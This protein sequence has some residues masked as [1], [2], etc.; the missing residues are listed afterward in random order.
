MIIRIITI[1]MG[2]SLGLVTASQGAERDTK[3]NTNVLKA[4][5]KGQRI[6][7]WIPQGI[8]PKERATVEAEKNGGLWYYNK[9]ECDRAQWPIANLGGVGWN[10]NRLTGTDHFVHVNI[11][12]EDQGVGDKFYDRYVMKIQ[13]RVFGIYRCLNRNDKPT[14]QL[15]KVMKKSDWRKRVTSCTALGGLGAVVAGGMGWLG[16]KNFDNNKR[17]SMVSLGLSGVGLLS[18]MYALYRY[19]TMGVLSLHDLSKELRKQ[20]EDNWRYI[21]PADAQD[22]MDIALFDQNYVLVMSPLINDRLKKY[23]YS[24][25]DY[26]LVHADTYTRPHHGRSDKDY[27]FWGDGVDFNT[28]TNRLALCEEGGETEIDHFLLLLHGSRFLVLSEQGKLPQ[29]KCEGL[30]KRENFDQRISLKVQV[31]NSDDSGANRKKGPWLY[32]LLSWFLS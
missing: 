32:A 2:L 27:Y 31:P 6:E 28:Y 19:S 9:F 14:L 26:C 20:I 16:A 21:R 7:P 29:E 10:W 15:V 30:E 8:S 3:S 23:Q 12:H 22:T 5:L 11:E 13:P 1:F 18:S 17:L 24:K 4:G 25:D